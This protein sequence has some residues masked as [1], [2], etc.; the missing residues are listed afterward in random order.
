MTTEQLAAL[1][2]G[3]FG[4]GLLTAYLVGMVRLGDL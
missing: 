2:L 1:V 3:A 4:V